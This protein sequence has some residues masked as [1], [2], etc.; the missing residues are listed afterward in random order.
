MFS[1]S[2]IFQ[3]QGMEAEKSRSQADG[4][5]SVHGMSLLDFVYK[6]KPRWVNH[7][8]ERPTSPPP[9]LFSLH[10]HPQL[11]STRTSSPGGRGP[12]R[13]AHGVGAGSRA[14]RLVASRNR[15]SLR[16]RAPGENRQETAGMR[17]AA[18]QRRRAG[19]LARETSSGSPGWSGW[20]VVGCPGCGGR[21]G[22]KRR[23]GW[24][25]TLETG[26]FASVMGKGRVNG[27]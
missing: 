3:G 14:I 21:E 17:E 13:A 26:G 19:G 5:N 1:Q 22:R 27:S 4:I 10:A 16:A 9:S 6:T 8:L 2:P 15:G 23:C 20:G 24:S 7:R 12:G 25:R 18:G 11:A